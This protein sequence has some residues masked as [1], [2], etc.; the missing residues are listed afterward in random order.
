[1]LPP[2]GQR[3]TKKFKTIKLIIDVNNELSYDRGRD[4]AKDRLYGTY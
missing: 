1:M 3:H 2:V 4:K